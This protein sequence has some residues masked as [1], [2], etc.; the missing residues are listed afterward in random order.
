[1][2]EADA[3]VAC[4][5]QQNIWKGRFTNSHCLAAPF[6]DHECRNMGYKGGIWQD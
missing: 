1:M 5:M 2:E 4:D 3:A 6:G